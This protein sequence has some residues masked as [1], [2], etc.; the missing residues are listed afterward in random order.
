MPSPPAL[1]KLPDEARIRSALTFAWT[2]QESYRWEAT[3]Q[4][5]NETPMQLKYLGSVHRETQQVGTFSRLVRRGANGPEIQHIRL[6]LEPN[7]R[8]QGFATAYWGHC[9]QRYAEVGLVRIRFTADSDG[10]LFWARDPVRFEDPATPR[11]LLTH[12]GGPDKLKRAGFPADDAERFAAEIEATPEAF[13]PAQLNATPMGQALL[14]EAGA[15]RGAIVDI[16]P[17]Y[18]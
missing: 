3:P 16:S 8:G 18:N 9:L 7:A 11:F 12:Y 17:P 14:S 5:V 1:S 15:G 2:D 13:T 10:R 6:E 4:L